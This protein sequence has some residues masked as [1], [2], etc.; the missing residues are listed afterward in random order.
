[1][2]Q[3]NAADPDFEVIADDDEEAVDSPYDEA[4]RRVAD[5]DRQVRQF[6]VEH[7][8][9]AVFGAVAVGY[10]VGRLVSRL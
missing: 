4:R 10:F 3:A 2:S 1:M 6:V 8:F 5:A 9:V 7:P